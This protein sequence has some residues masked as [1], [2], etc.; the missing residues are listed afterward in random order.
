MRTILWAV[1]LTAVL[2]ACAGQ[3]AVETVEVT[4]VVEIPGPTAPPVEVTR[5]VEKETAVEVTRE[6]EVTRLVEVPVEVIVTPTQPPMPQTFL[7]LSGEGDLV[8]DNFDWGPCQKA[9]F[10][11]DAPGTR[12]F[13]VH[14]WNTTAERPAGLVNEI[15]PDSGE[16]LQPLAGG[17]YYL[18]IQATNTTWTITGE[19]RD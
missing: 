5:L 7:E 6:V 17:S 1:V 8:T 10:V 12:N 9:V 15:A 4:R 3:T 19:C 18:E 11:W 14:L 13:I 2:S 16:V